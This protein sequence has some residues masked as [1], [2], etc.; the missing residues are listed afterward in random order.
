MNLSSRT[1]PELLHLKSLSFEA[2][3]LVGEKVLHSLRFD[4]KTP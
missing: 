1:I 4:I 3:D 2:P